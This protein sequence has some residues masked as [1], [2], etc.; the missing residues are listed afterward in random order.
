MV[1]GGRRRRGR[2]GDLDATD[3]LVSVDFN[4]T[5]L[6]DRGPALDG[7][8][9]REGA[10]GTIRG[11]SCVRD[12]PLHGKIAVACPSSASA[13]RPR[14]QRL[15]PIGLQCSPEGQAR[16]HDTRIVAALSVV[17]TSGG[18]R[19]RARVSRPAKGKSGLFGPWQSGSGNPRR[20]ALAPDCASR[21]GNSRG[22]RTGRNLLLE[23]ALPRRG[24][25]KRQLPAGH[26]RESTSTIL[27]RGTPVTPRSRHHASPATRACS[28]ALR[29]HLRAAPGDC[30]L[31]G[32][33]VSISSRAC[34]PGRWLP[35][36]RR[37]GNTFLASLGHGD[38][39]WS[40]IGSGDAARP[41]A[42]PR[43][44]GGSRWTLS[45]AGSTARRASAPSA[46]GDPADLMGS[47]SARPFSSS[48]KR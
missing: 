25:G 19:R 28:A 31:G 21:T 33:K 13:A 18:R 17:L 20:R 34:S 26:P 47:T 27:R 7:D 43:R 10:R 32:A 5:A 38:R 6:V 46:S 22:R 37:H 2:S 9:H 3:G 12:D 1:G 39:C 41:R 48:A 30:L 29:T 16:E 42:G 36:R 15:P 40:R 8:R 23:P 35:H 11:Y 4:G 14:G 44:E 24:G 45:R